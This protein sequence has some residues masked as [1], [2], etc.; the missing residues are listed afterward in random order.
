MK[1]SFD[2]AFVAAAGGAGISKG[3]GGYTAELCTDECTDEWKEE[4]P[5]ACIINKSCQFV[6]YSILIE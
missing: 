2:D 1:H 3:G 4:A 5:M 6:Q